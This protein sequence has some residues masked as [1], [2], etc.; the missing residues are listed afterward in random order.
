MEE[1]REERE[2]KLNFYRSVNI[3][4]YTEEAAQS[5][6]LKPDEELTIQDI[7]EQLATYASFGMGTDLNKRIERFDTTA[8][9]DPIMA[10]F[11]NAMMTDCMDA[12]LPYGD[13]SE[14]HRCNKLKEM[15][16]DLMK[17]QRPSV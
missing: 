15:L 7:F 2:S 9:K 1:L 3:G 12:G 10:Q 6:H 14:V 17:N 16:R 11:K 13:M 4:N 8:E 5:L